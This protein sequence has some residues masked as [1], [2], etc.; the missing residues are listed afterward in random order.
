[1]FG[2]IAWLAGVLL[3]AACGGS[4][5]DDAPADVLARFLEAMDRSTLN[6]TAL[7]DAYAL[8]DQD[9][10][11]ELLARAD[12]AGF[13]TGRKFDGWEMIAHGRFRLRFTPAEHGEMRTTISGDE[14]Q[15]VVRSEDARGS[16]AVPLVRE[17]GRWRVRL[18]LPELPRTASLGP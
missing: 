14:A 6:E 9:A 11:H 16:V 4:D 2:R 15:V 12:R 3:A 17:S 8:L 1:M 5:A 7:K 18:A 13:L 10:Q